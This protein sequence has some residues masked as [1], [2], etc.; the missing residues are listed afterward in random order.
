MMQKIIPGLR[1][2][3][4]YS[5]GKDSVLAIHRAIQG[6]MKLQA[7]L[8]TYNTDR[9]RSWFH[10]IPE[11]ILQAVSESVGVPVRLIRTAGTSYAADFEAALRE[12]RALGAEACVFGDIDIQGH[13]DWCTERCLAAGLQPCFPLWQE[14]RRAL[15]EECLQSGFR[16]TITVVDTKRL[17]A[18]F[19]ARP[20]TRE[21]L[22]QMEQAGVDAC[23]ENGEYHSFVADG[24][25]FSRP[26]PVSFGETFLLDGY[27][28][29]PLT[30][31]TNGLLSSARVQIYTG[32]GKGKTTAALGLMLRAAGAG[33]K[34]Y[35][36]QFMKRG[37][38][39]E[40]QAIH[41][42]L[43]DSITVEQHGSGGELACPDRERDTACARTGYE[44][45]RQALY[46]GKYDLVVLD[47]IFV[48]VH[49][50][51]LEEADVLRL[52]E[53][54]PRHTELILT[55]RYAPPSLMEKADLVTEMGEIRHY[56][57]QGLA[58]RVGIEK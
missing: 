57:H 6:G 22:D 47:E 32:N 10:G 19:A 11:E 31:R 5:G 14:D 18:G 12:Q 20:L 39:S 52:F 15:A 54:R 36:G 27:A 58:A 34:S 25:I 42:F 55:G 33:G 3:A 9:G 53:E 23:G 41:R 37:N 30:L 40:I 28:I 46:S 21:A 2:V 7:L 26:I 8:I 51:L 29:A 16:P 44:K 38:T 17:A 49:L 48:A 13:L 45:A 43:P 1:F 4:S 50:H 56:F 35:F 24:P